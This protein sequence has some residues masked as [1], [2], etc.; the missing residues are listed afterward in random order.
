MLFMDP[1]WDWFSFYMRTVQ[2]QTGT[3][4]TR[5]GSAVPC[6]RIKRNVWRAIRTHTGL[7]SSRS[8]I[9]TPL[10][11][12]YKPMKICSSFG[13]KFDVNPNNNNTAWV[14]VHFWIIFVTR[15]KHKFEGEIW[16]I[17]VSSTFSAYLR[18]DSHASFT[19][20]QQIPLSMNFR[21]GS[22]ANH[23]FNT[24]YMC[25][26]FVDLHRTIFVVPKTQLHVA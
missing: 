10:F 13:C 3:K 22:S 25:G 11:S 16:H 17:I 8:H 21:G 12:V 4:I 26:W 18:A 14:S 19:F 1:V 20:R 5:V 15:L 24:F 2:S 6:K 9:I 7:S 23:W